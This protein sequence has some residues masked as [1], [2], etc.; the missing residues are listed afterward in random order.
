MLYNDVKLVP[1]SSKECNLTQTELYNQQTKYNLLAAIPC[2]QH[3]LH[4]FTCNTWLSTCQENKQTDTIIVVVSKQAMPTFL[5][6]HN[7]I[8]AGNDKL[9]VQYRA[10][11]KHRVMIS[12]SRTTTTSYTND[13]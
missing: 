6:S 10:C 8:K 2:K 12:N 5:T 4:N 7:E 9:V 3:Y 11:M 13:R 1:V